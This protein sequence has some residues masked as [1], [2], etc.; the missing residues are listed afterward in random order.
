[1]LADKSTLSGDN[2][3]LRYFGDVDFEECGIGPNKP[4]ILH[5]SIRPADLGDDECISLFP[6]SCILISFSR[7]G[8]ENPW[9]ATSIERKRMLQLCNLIKAGLARHQRVNIQRKRKIK[10][11]LESGSRVYTPRLP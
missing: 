2:Y 6:L 9:N 8:Q 3:L 11:V 10:K 5:V 1:M 4:N 7:V